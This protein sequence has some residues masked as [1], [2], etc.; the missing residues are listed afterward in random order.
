MAEEHIQMNLFD[1]EILHPNCT[2]QE[3]RNAETGEVSFGWWENENP[4]KGVAKTRYDQVKAMSLE[5][6]AN[7]FAEIEGDPYNGATIGFW[8]D[9]LKEE[10]QE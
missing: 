9:W 3:L 7:E 2:V 1:E 8:L 4:P 5:E 10:V 6:M